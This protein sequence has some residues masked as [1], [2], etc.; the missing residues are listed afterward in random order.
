[1]DSQQDSVHLWPNFAPMRH[2]LPSSQSARWRIPIQYEH[3][4]YLQ[5]TAPE[6]EG[7]EKTANQLYLEERERRLHSRANDPA[8]SGPQSTPSPTDFECAETENLRRVER[9]GSG[10]E[11]TVSAVNTRNRVDKSTRPGKRLS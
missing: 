10:S 11:R 8:V 7:V 2:T 5:L 9:L 4:I 3:E 1:M 6:N